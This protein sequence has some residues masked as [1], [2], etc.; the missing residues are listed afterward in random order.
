M[1]NGLFSTLH[2]LAATDGGKKQG[3]PSVLVTPEKGRVKGGKKRKE[4]AT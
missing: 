3:Y 4:G 1:T 2:L